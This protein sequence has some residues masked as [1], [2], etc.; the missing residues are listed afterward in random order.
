MIFLQLFY[1]FFLIG[2]FGFGG[3][4]AMISM[5]QGEVVTHHHWLTM[6][7]FT[8]VIAVSQMTPGPIGVNAATFVGYRAVVNAGYSPLIGSMGSALATFAEMLPQFILMIV[9]LRILMK[10]WNHP[11]KIMIF[12]ALRP[13]IV[14]LI[15]A[16]AL[17]LMT[18]ENFGSPSVSL[19]QFCISVFLFLSTFIGTYYFKINPIKMICLCGAAGFLLYF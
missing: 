17:L 12:S 13:T 2:L 15:A 19:W 1:T 8:D 14:G 9:V 3:G 16:A 11:I 5:I 7:E 4:Y 6:Q 10:Y 18:S